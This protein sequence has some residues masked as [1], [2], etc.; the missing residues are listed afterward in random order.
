MERSKNAR[1]VAGKYDLFVIP[2]FYLKREKGESDPVTIE[3]W[4]PSNI[5]SDSLS[6]MFQYRTVIKSKMAAKCEGCSSH[7]L[8][9]LE[10]RLSFAHS[11][12]DSLRGWT[13]W[14]YYYA[15]DVSVASNYCTFF[16]RSGI[17]NANLVLIDRLSNILEISNFKREHLKQ[18]NEQ[19]YMCWCYAC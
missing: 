11:T 19:R 6:D 7:P 18:I 3:T 12:R 13:P 10:R 2:F 4:P 15:T 9:P 8:F 14:I 5:S 16:F 17:A 1:N